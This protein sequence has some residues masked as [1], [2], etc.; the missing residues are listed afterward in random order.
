MAKIKCIIKRPDEKYGHVTHI[1]DRLENLQKTVGGYIETVPAIQGAVIICNEEGKL[2]GLE[3]NM[4]Y[5][6]DRLV[7]T[8]IVIGTKGDEFADIPISLAQWKTFVDKQEELGP[9]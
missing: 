8:I 5:F 9:L 2:Q 7:G 6:H 4:W 3:P 1:S